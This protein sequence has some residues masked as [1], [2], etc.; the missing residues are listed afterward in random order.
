MSLRSALTANL[1]LKLTSLVL[2]LLLWLLA[3]S[4]EP[5][6]VSLELRRRDG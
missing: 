2:A 6:S 4:E 5:D 3:A 1:P